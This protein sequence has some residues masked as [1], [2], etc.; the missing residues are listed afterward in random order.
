MGGLD[1]IPDERRFP[2]GHERGDEGLTVR[3][4][5][6]NPIKDP[7]A[8]HQDQENDCEENKKKLFHGKAPSG[9]TGS[10]TLARSDNDSC[11]PR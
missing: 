7:G 6:E 3:G 1:A 9:M 11:Q 10:T 8:S 4:I 5:V 2:R